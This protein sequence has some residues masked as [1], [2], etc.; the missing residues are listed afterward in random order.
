MVS[1]A[2]ILN[3]LAIFNTSASGDN[4]I[5]NSADPEKRLRSLHSQLSHNKTHK[6]TPSSLDVLTSLF[7]PPLSNLKVWP[8]RSWTSGADTSPL[9][10]FEE[11]LTIRKP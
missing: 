5:M 6:Q 8:P 1:G 11:N 7:P 10:G 2:A 3:L 9:S 4:D